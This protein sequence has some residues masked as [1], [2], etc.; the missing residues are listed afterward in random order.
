MTLPLHV[1]I[2]SVRQLCKCPHWSET[3][4]WRITYTPASTMI[5]ELETIWKAS[6]VTQSRLHTITC[7]DQKKKKLNKT[8]RWPGRDSQHKTP[9]HKP[10]ALLLHQ[11]VRC[12]CVTYRRK[13]STKL[14]ANEKRQNV[15]TRPLFSTEQTTI[16]ELDTCSLTLPSTTLRWH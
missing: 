10:T 3:D 14:N 13:A 5:D 15:T 6:F 8:S 9:T 1:Q 11:P 7:L 4:K 16:I 2:R 12:K